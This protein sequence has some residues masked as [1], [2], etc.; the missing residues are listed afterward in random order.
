MASYRSQP[1]GYSSTRLLVLRILQELLDAVP[2]QIEQQ[3]EI[4]L[5]F[6][7]GHAGIRTTAL[8]VMRVPRQ[9]QSL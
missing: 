3:S 2:R 6:R 5:N 7:I 4:V 1:G 8:P 9:L